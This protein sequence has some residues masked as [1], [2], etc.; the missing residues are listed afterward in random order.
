MLSIIL[1]NGDM[2]I[3]DGGSRFFEKTGVHIINFSAGDKNL[4]LSVLRSGV[5]T[6]TIS[7]IEGT[8]TPGATT[9][10][11]KAVREKL[12]QVSAE[13]H[14]PINYVFSTWNERMLAWA[15]SSGREVFNWDEITQY[16]EGLIVCKKKVDSTV[17]L[18]NG[19][20]TPRLA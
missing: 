2:E 13:Q 10:L 5:A 16:E 17:P 20:Q 3:L 19:S 14:R 15:L 6:T 4:R 12:H 18:P 1:Y 8:E 11:Y 7:T 9:A